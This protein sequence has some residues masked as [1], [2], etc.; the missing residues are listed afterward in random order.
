MLDDEIVDALRLLLYVLQPFVHI[1]FL[2]GIHDEAPAFRNDEVRIVRDSSIQ[3][4]LGL[5]ESDVP[6]IDSDISDIL[7]YFHD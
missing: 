6:V 4:I 2:D 3:W 7:C 1:A 5:E